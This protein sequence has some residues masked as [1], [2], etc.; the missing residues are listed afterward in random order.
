M[1]ES[2]PLIPIV[3]LGLLVAGV[4]LV[5]RRDLDRGARPRPWDLAWAVPAALVLLA[6]AVVCSLGL[7]ERAHDGL[8]LAILSAAALVEGACALLRRPVLDTL[9]RLA[10]RGETWRARTEALRAAAAAGCVIF[11]CA[12]GWVALELP[13]NGSILSMGPTFSALE[14]LIILVFLVLLFFVSQR[15]GAGV[16]AGVWA[17]WVTG[18]AQYF[19]ARFKEAAILPNDLLALGTAAEV[20]GGYVFSVN[21]LVA[22]GTAAA[23]LATAACAFAVPSRCAARE[24]LRRN[25]LGNAAAALVAAGCLW[26]VVSTDFGE[27]YGL[28]IAYWNSLSSY[29][30]HGFLPSFIKVAQDLPIERPQG[31]S[32]EAAAQTEGAYAAAYDAGRG[33]SPERAAA[34]EQFDQVRPSVV[35][36]MNET[37]SD[38]SIYD[39][40]GVGYAGPTFYRS[41]AS[42]PRT[43][44]S[45][46]LAVSVLGGGTCNTEFELLT[47]VPLAYVGNG[48][49]PFMLYDLEQSPSL[50]AQL[51]E[52]GYTT[53]AIHPNQPGN[54]NRSTV[55]EALGFDEFL[56]Y[57][58]FKTGTGDQEF[59]GVSF[60]HG[61]VSDGETYGK[62]LELLREDDQ[63][64][65]IFDVTMQ[66]HGGYLQS[67]VPIEDLPGYEPAGLDA[68]TTAE[69]GEYLACISASDR[70]LER[71]VSELAT[72]DRPVIVIF[73]GDHQPD[74][75]NELA[76]ALLPDADEA[77]AARL[78]YSTTYTIWAN[79]DVAG[80]GGTGAATDPSSPSYLAAMALDAAGAPLTDYQ[81]AQLAARGEIRALS[82]VG[83]ELS[84]GTWV[85]LEEED[86]SLPAA[87]DDLAQITYLEF[88]SKVE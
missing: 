25:V 12:L 15:R 13:W 84:D 56:S 10:G 33:S 67:N 23:L 83:T 14:A 60:Y 40:L 35:C 27:A 2:T 9:D 47:G 81:K 65:F 37:F 39:G 58:D 45:G 57:D 30:S 1:L 6:C 68:Q 32:D 79:Y 78:V 86:A 82:L 55:Y 29:E 62:I 24:D 34:E 59:E 49:Y 73:F 61:A 63:P 41:W 71:F 36:I 85:P 44:G 66:N 3:A 19:V 38:L 28:E 77:Q 87:Y 52:L 46:S 42:D 88:A 21:H 4:V 11:S 16:A 31:Y 70:D 26:G 48:K 72:L 75:S 50:P 51:S 80:S 43:V 76:A 7:Y 8:T 5:V 53:T 54:W 18:V 17:L 22:L 64:Q 69:L 74:F 20:S